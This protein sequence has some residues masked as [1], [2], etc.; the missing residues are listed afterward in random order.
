MSMLWRLLRSKSYYER[1]V[2]EAVEKLWGLVFSGYHLVE[3]N[4]PDTWQP[5]LVAV[6]GQR[7]T[8]LIV[9]L[10]GRPPSGTKRQAITQVVEY[11]E[12]FHETFPGVPV[13]LL[14][15][16]PWEQDAWC[17]HVAMGRYTVG[18]ISIENLGYGLLHKAEQ[19]LLWCQ[20]SPFGCLHPHPCAG[21]WIAE[22]PACVGEEGT[23]ESEAGEA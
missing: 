2:Q 12:E 3:V 16:G 17:E 1:D 14:V 13:R 4:M 20:D 22:L 11:A 15:I 7:E 21:E 10:K 5:D 19:I 9:E 6:D 18:V 23:W 8:Y